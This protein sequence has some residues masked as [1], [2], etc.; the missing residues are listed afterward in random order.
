MNNICQDID[1]LE[2]QCYTL[3][4]T[5]TVRGEV[6]TINLLEEASLYSGNARLY[7]INNKYPVG[8]DFYSSNTQAININ[9]NSI[10]DTYNSVELGINTTKTVQST[11]LG[12]PAVARFYSD[13][14]SRFSVTPACSKNNGS[15][16]VMAFRVIKPV[17]L[18]LLN[19]SN[20]G[21]RNLL[22]IYDHTNNMLLRTAN[23]Y[24]LIISNK[25]ENGF[26]NG[27]N[28]ASI[29][30]MYERYRTRKNDD[31]IIDRIKRHYKRYSTRR[32]DHDI[33]DYIK[34]F[35]QDIFGLVV[36]G[37]Y[38]PPESSFHSEI[39]IFN[40]LHF[41]ARDYTDPNDFQYN[42]GYMNAP[43]TVKAWMRVMDV[44]H[45]YNV[46]G[47][48][49][50]LLDHMTWCV[51]YA[52]NILRDHPTWFPNITPYNKFLVIS[53]AMFHDIG[54]INPDSSQTYKG[55][56]INLYYTGDTN[57]TKHGVFGY[58][59]F[60]NNTF[61]FYSDNN[62]SIVELLTDI[63]RKYLGADP[64]FLLVDSYRRTLAYICK[65][66]YDLGNEY[67]NSNNDP[68]IFLRSL[69]HLINHTWYYSYLSE[70]G[71]V[72]GLYPFYVKM[73]IVVSISDMLSTK[74]YLETD[75]SYQFRH[76]VSSVFPFISNRSSPWNSSS[77][78]Y[79]KGQELIRFLVS[80]N[81]M[82]NIETYITAVPPK[83]QQLVYINSDT[84]VINVKGRDAL[85]WRTTPQVL[86]YSIYSNV[87]NNIASMD[88]DYPSPPLIP[89]EIDY[90]SPPLSPMEID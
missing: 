49:G 54:K 66:H 73:L 21:V 51:L 27:T 60:M 7:E 22:I 65:H 14:S 26:F 88:V 67:K 8:P 12:T 4:K 30:L 48:S 53:A 87:R 42:A 69:L 41:L 28:H 90:P 19:S 3:N 62:L 17:R 80:N 18:L 82:E 40:I 64:N 56:K 77:F 10:I 46:I 35:S 89:M 61:I 37:Y 34:G 45:T 47:H 11:W 63:L 70:V 84:F 85:T 23:D 50:H 74:K 2:P 20:E 6:T 72:L 76:A 36:D 78:L 79:V 58:E 5:R 59:I 75:K 71:E 16:C 24:Y 32:D 68:Q 1:N 86:R 44:Y 81:F 39:C 13:Q 57:T 55:D 38:S 52:E 25:I 15:N 43:L 31:D 9:S 83:T 29:K 33:I